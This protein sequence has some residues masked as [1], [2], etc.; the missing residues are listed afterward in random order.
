LELYVRNEYFYI[1]GVSKVCSF[2]CHGE[3]K[4]THAKLN[5]ELEMHNEQINKNHTKYGILVSL[6]KEKAL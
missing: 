6:A 4:E 2:V 5:S 3:I 1:G